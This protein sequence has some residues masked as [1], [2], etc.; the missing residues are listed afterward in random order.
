MVYFDKKETAYKD[1]IRENPKG[2]VINVL[3]KP[4]PEYDM[5]HRAKCYTIRFSVKGNEI[6]RWTT[7]ENKKR[8]SLD[9]TELEESYRKEV[10]G[11]FRNCKK[12]RP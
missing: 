1:W 8:C 9:R 5:L 12:C 11:K 7:G 10:G 2:Y 6:N 4:N 3:E